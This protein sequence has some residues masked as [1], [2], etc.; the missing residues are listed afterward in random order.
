MW[1]SHSTFRRVRVRSTLSNVSPFLSA[2]M[3]EVSLEELPSPVAINFFFSSSGALGDVGSL[4][5]P[6]VVIA[7]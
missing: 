6:L 3:I 2:Y 4:P 1:E 7:P 5:V